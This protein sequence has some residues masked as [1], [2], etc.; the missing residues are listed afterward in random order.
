MN[1]RVAGLV[2]D[3]ACNCRCNDLWLVTPALLATVSNLQCDLN[4]Q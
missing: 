4:L 2:R 3:H 1:N